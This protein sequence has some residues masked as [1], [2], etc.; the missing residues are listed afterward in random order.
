M[1]SLT[2]SHQRCKLSLVATLLQS[3]HPPK[4]ELR[5]LN[6]GPQAVGSNLSHLVRNARRSGGPRR[7]ERKPRR[8]RPPDLRAVPAGSLHPGHHGPDPPEWLPSA[9]VEVRDIDLYWLP[10]ALPKPAITGGIEQSESVRPLAPNGKRFRLY[11]RA[12][13]DLARPKLLHNRVSYL[14]LRRHIAGPFDLLARPMLPSINTLTIR[15]DPIDGHRMYLH[16][17]DAKATAVAGGMFHV[18]PAGVFQPADQK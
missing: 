5:R 12:L 2:F 14:P 11:A 3:I 13:R 18:I 9:P 8:A 6:E 4:R 7:T 17:R 10:D 16:R 15:T 1:I